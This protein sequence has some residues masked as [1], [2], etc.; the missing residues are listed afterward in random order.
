M[1]EPDD[2]ND[3]DDTFVIRATNTVLFNTDW[4][5]ADD[6]KG[7]D[8][9][10]VDDTCN[11]WSCVEDNGCEVL[12]E[13]DNH[14][15]AFAAAVVGEV[16]SI[17]LNPWVK[18]SVVREVVNVVSFREVDIAIMF[19]G[20]NDEFPDSKSVDRIRSVPRGFVR[21]AKLETTG[22]VELSRQKVSFF[23]LDSFILRLRV[24][25]NNITKVDN[26]QMKAVVFLHRLPFRVLSQF[27]SSGLG[28]NND[29]CG[30]FNV[31]DSSQQKQNV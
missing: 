16:E 27:E 14:I 7:E 10:D 5:V 3:D 28:R 22:P 17:S 29:L 12:R 9:V 24:V 18:E 25:S 20:S 11:A 31:A 15:V 6:T 30:V 4:K 19:D 23:F 2:D 26:K 21:V 8:W 13:D 1:N